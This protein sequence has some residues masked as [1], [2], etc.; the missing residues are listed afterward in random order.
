MTA[1]L[2]ED[3]DQVL[4]PGRHWWNDRRWCEHVAD[5]PYDTLVVAMAGL[6]ARLRRGDDP[7]WVVGDTTAKAAFDVAGQWL[8]ACIPPMDVALWLA[9]GCNRPA[10]ARLLVYVGVY[11]QVLLDD[12]GE[13]A[14]RAFVDL[15]GRR[16]SVA[17]AVAE[18][19]L[20]PTEAARIVRG[21]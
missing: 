8:D 9:A 6:A 1:G 19:L 21:Q 15:D 12:R 16:I 7:A 4:A 13:V 17:L 2:A 3:I 5:H 18:G 14:P 11:P 10:S 20:T